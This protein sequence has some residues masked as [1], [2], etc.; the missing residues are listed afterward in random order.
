MGIGERGSHSESLL[1]LE[2]SVVDG[3]KV[4]VKKTGLT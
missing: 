4:K 2:F 1:S 3:G